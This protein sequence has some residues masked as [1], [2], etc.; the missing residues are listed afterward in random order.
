MNQWKPVIAALATALLLFGSAHLD[1]RTPKP[2]TNK[3]FDKLADAALAAMTQKAAEL[4]ISGVAAVS[5]APGA[6]VQGWWSRMAVAGRMTDPQTAG[7]KGNNLIGIAYSKSAEM[8]ETLKDSGTAG[9]PPMTGEYGWQGGVT[10]RLAGGNII[11]AFSGG[12]SEDDVQVS[13]AGLAVMEAG[14]R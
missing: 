3:K 2:V 6:R 5:F 9:R 1:A 11:V 4:K 13:K 8:A 7:N 14:L 12:R 10:A